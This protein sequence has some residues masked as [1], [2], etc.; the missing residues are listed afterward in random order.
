[1]RG[2][3]R[4]VTFRDRTKYFGCPWIGSFVPKLFLH[5]H[6]HTHTRIHTNNSKVHGVCGVCLVC[7]EFVCV[8][9]VELI[10]RVSVSISVC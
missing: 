5:T 9:S 4:L 1:M 2:V 6:T 8:V 10:M 7:G 3:P